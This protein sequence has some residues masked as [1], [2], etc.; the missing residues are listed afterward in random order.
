MAT[1]IHPTAIIDESVR[2]GDGTLV[3]ANVHI[4]GGVRIG[5]NCNICDTVF[6]ENGVSVGN[7]VTIKNGCM[8][9]RG[10]AIEDGAFIGPNVTFTNDRYPRSP[11]HI[12]FEARYDND[13]WLG[14]T[15]V[16]VGAAIGA[17]A[18]L[19][20]PVDIGEYALVGAGSVVTKDVLPYSLVVGNPAKFVCWICKCTAKLS[21]SPNKP[22]YT[23]ACG[24]SFRYTDFRVSCL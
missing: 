12:G 23:C 7:N 5:S 20:A 13:D 22:V 4:L 11:R 2:I 16:R 18:V 15:I 14:R 8:L 10:V 19:V 3:W 21:I 17:G 24:K 6:M 1:K 9:W